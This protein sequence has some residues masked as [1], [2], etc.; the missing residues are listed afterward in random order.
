M[1]EHISDLDYENDP[2]L[3][4][5]VQAELSKRY[6]QDGHEFFLSLVELLERA[7]PDATQVE[8]SGGWFAKKVPTRVVVSLGDIRYTLQDTGRGLVARL[9]RWKHGIAL[10]SEEMPVPDWITALDA[11]L[12]AHAR[13]SQTARDALSKFSPF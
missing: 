13:T 6:A 4:F 1:S 9:E 3:K 5:S 10:K 11:S 12:S 7:L 2:L 8:R